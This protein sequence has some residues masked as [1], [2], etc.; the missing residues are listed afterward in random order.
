MNTQ[1]NKAF[2]DAT[3]V[4]LQVVQ[5]L[6]SMG[7]CDDCPC[8]LDADRCHAPAH[9]SAGQRMVRCI[10][11]GAVRDNI[12]KGM[13]AVPSGLSKSSDCRYYRR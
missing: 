3:E 13:V 11:A 12:Q 4:E 2:S 1:E 9:I 8:N 7:V 5:P 6:P 10:G